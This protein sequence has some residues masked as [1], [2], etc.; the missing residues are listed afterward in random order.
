MSFAQLQGYAVTEAQ[1]WIPRSGAWWGDLEISSSVDLTGAATLTMGSLT[2]TGAVVRGSSYRGRSRYRIAGGAEW[3]QRIPR[4]A[5]RAD[6][7]VRRSTVLGDAARECGARLAP[8]APEAILGTAWVR[9]E[10]PASDARDRALLGASWYI[11]GIGT[12]VVGERPAGDVRANYVIERLDHGQRI[13]VIASSAPEAFVP[14]LTLADVGV[15][16]TVALMLRS[17]L[18]VHCWG[19]A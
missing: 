19:A 9:P 5:Y 12:L 7:G 3:R 10:G 13:A 6:A 2:L 4:R 8:G 18:R 11:D 17:T 16:D 15:L 1:I 14:G